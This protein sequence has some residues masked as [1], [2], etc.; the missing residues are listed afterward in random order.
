MGWQ[1]VGNLNVRTAAVSDIAGDSNGNIYVAY[2]DWFLNRI[3]V[4][5]W[6]GSTWAFLGNPPG[7]SM[8]SST[9][10][11]IALSTGG[12]PYIAYVDTTVGYFPVVRKW[13]GTNWVNVGANGI[14]DSVMVSC[15]D[16]AIDTAGTPVLAYG[17]KTAGGKVC[18]WS[19][20]A[21][22]TLGS[23]SFFSK[24]ISGVRLILRRDGTPYVSYCYSDPLFRKE[25]IARLQSNNIWTSIGQPIDVFALGDIGFDKNDTLYEVH[26]DYPLYSPDY[27][28]ILRRYSDTA[29]TE[30][31]H[32]QHWTTWAPKIMLDGNNTPYIAAAEGNGQSEAHVLSYDGSAL[33]YMASIGF[34]GKPEIKSAMTIDD[35]G[36]PYVLSIG[37]DKPDTGVVMMHDGN[38]WISLGNP[39]PFNPTVHPPN[40]SLDIAVFRSEVYIVYLTINGA[41][42]VM[43]YDGN[44][45]NA[46]GDR[47]QMPRAYDGAIVI[48]ALG[49]P[50]VAYSQYCGVPHVIKFDGVNW[51]P[52]GAPLDSALA[53]Q[54]IS[55][56]IAKNGTP[57]VCYQR[58]W[59]GELFVK[60]FNGTSWIDLGGGVHPNHGTN[61]FDM[62]LDTAGVPYVIYGANHGLTVRYYNGN[63]WSQLGGELLPTA[64]IL[65]VSIAI[66]TDNT[67][68]A[69]YTEDGGGFPTW[70]RRASIAAPTWADIDNQPVS[71][72]R[73]DMDVHI[74]VKNGNPIVCWTNFGVYAKQYFQTPALAIHNVARTPESRLQLLP[75]PT[76]RNL[77]AKISDSN[78]HKFHIVIH[79]VAGRICYSRDVFTNGNTTIEI[80]VAS[81]L[82]GAYSVSI[83]SDTCTDIQRFIKQ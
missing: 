31:V 65:A 3:S 59:L 24:G 21:W 30:I 29:Y 28:L 38:K 23:S 50:Y 32:T 76:S 60:Q 26:G 49:T 61:Y 43:H 12:A 73:P 10:L 78:A 15:L 20:S 11:S 16:L 33:K 19:G 42:M 66:D 82:P 53:G 83:Q 9:C 39:I 2:T 51:V 41:L 79:D 4:Q 7:I 47:L 14:A 69:A 58:G 35:K 81:F 62:V 18:K 72:G 40:V 34:T 63:S 8:A 1:T 45:W 44:S 67:V 36:R 70:A 6:D 22:V 48:D 77:V 55:I 56:A 13:N 80:P 71:F 54:S 75:N 27:N 57:Y 74:S 64:S 5:K 46:V 37:F 68:Y 52:V 25:V 17:I